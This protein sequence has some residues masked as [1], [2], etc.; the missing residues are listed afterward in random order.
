ME[1]IIQPDATAAARL[2]A[3]LIADAVNA[4]GG[5]AQAFP[6]FGAISDSLRAKCSSGDVIL[7]MGAGDVT[8]LCD[9][10]IQE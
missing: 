2:T 10:L 9:L 6:D 8:N 5:H 1:V 7:V 3:R 4:Q